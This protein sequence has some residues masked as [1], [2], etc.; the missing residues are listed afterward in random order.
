[1]PPQQKQSK[2]IPV[3]LVMI[4]VAL[5]GL[6]FLSLKDGLPKNSSEEEIL[7]EDTLEEVVYDYG[8]NITIATHQ[9]SNSLSTESKF[10]YDFAS[11]KN[12]ANIPFTS[13]FDLNSY[14]NLTMNVIEIPPN[15]TIFSVDLAGDS[16]LFEYNEET[17]QFKSLRVDGEYEI[18]KQGMTKNL[19]RYNQYG[20]GDGCFAGDNYLIRVPNKMYWLSLSFSAIV[21]ES[22]EEDV[23]MS[24]EKNLEIV[25][26]IKFK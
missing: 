4:F 25:N 20:Q 7:V 2:T 26:S 11:K 16:A 3:L 13:N 6:G 9:F 18:F 24:Y 17:D 15:K 10:V 23:G 22:S 21:C 14:K 5:L 19:Y 12:I 1:M 8:K